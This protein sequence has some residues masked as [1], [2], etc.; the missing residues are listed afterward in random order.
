MT[1]HRSDLGDRLRRSALWANSLAAMLAIAGVVGW[2][3]D[4]PLL[5]AYLEG[6]PE[7]TPLTG[8]GLLAT[9][10]ALSLLQRGN[11]NARRS[12]FALLGATALAVIA[13]LFIPAAGSLA[14]GAIPVYTGSTMLL[15]LAAI[16]LAYQDRIDMLHAA[17]I[18]AGSA[19]ALVYI[20]IMAISFRLLM[21]APPLLQVSLPSVVVLT[22]LVYSMFAGRPDPWFLDRLTSQR[23]GA[24]ITRQ[25]LP[26]ILALPLVLG[27]IRLLG[28]RAGLFDAAFGSL[29]LAVLT[30]MLLGMLVLWGAETL[31]QLDARRTE[32]E[33]H[34]STQ[35]E[36]LRVT[37]ASCNDAVVAADAAGLVRFVNPAAQALIGGVEDEWIGRPMEEAVPLSDEAGKA[38]RHPVRTVLQSETHAAGYR[39]LLLTSPG[40]ASHFVEASVAP[41]YDDAHALLGAVMVMRDVSLR[42]QNDQALRAAYAELDRRVADRTSALER[43]NAALHESL[44]LF[45]GVAES[46]PDLIYVKDREGRLVMANPATIKVIGKPENEILGRT[47]SEF[48]ANDAEAQRVMETDRRVLS[49]GRVERIEE[50]LTTPEGER[51][52]LSTKSPLH[53]IQG[54]IIGLI[55]VATDITER[56]RMENELREAQR[57]TQGLLETAPI[58]LYLFDLAQRRVVYA[59]GMGLSGLG[60]NPSD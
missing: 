18:L 42:R 54:N 21:E 11:I 1:P 15:L 47:D 31:D 17:H 43:A 32:A 38:I 16:A 3:A 7:V 41:I 8:M 46:T 34:A 23:P 39:E 55:G 9:T 5:N 13:G 53:D 36:W 49:S 19:A 6:W 45:R 52:Y 14:G 27:S 50:V 57:F 24:V 22:L 2:L 56:K 37:L 26:A 30:I 40:G 33:H 59:S 44:A 28:Q 10:G 25:L 60:Y 48:L 35:R 51:T 58:I 29:L 4:I 12:A 20:A